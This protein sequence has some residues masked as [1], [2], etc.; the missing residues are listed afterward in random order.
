MKAMYM[1]NY[2][3][4]FSKDSLPTATA[5]CVIFQSIDQHWPFSIISWEYQPVIL[6]QGNYTWPFPSEGMHTYSIYTICFLSKV[7]QPTQ[8]LK[9]YRK[10]FPYT[11]YPSRHCFRSKD[12]LYGE[13]III[14][15]SWPWEVF[16][17]SYTTPF[18]R[19]WPDE[20][21]EQSVQDSA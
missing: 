10:A 7:S 4:Y 2:M 14:V 13:V 3:G 15:G 1:T 9:T 8:Y 17:L 21:W 20:I 19:S 18:T 16:I 11:C 12:L 6:W 5:V